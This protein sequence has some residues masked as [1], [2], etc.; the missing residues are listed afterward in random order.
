MISVGGN[1]YSVRDTTRRQTLEVQLHAEEL[2]IFEDGQLA[3][4]RAADRTA[5]TLQAFFFA[6]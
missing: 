5:G 1:F 2:R 6:F 4:G 3:S